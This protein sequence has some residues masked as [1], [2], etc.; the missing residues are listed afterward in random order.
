MTG[1]DGEWSSVPHD[2]ALYLLLTMHSC[3]RP[4][5]LP[6]GRIAREFCVLF[7]VAAV[8]AVWPLACLSEGD[9]LGRRLL[10]F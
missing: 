3:Q 6:T 8:R 9:S 10:H 2:A 5:R 1:S 4:C 7:V